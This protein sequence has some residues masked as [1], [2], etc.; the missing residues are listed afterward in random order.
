VAFTRHELGCRY[1]HVGAE[2]DQPALVQGMLKML[3][4]LQ[5]RKLASRC[6]WW[7]FPEETLRQSASRLLLQMMRYATWEDVQA[8]LQHYGARA[9]KDALV[10]APAGALDPRSWNFWHL[11]LGLAKAPDDVPPMPTRKVEDA[12]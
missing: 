10:S 3:S 8:A 9:F 11:Y 1:D 6:V 7:L 2:I 5:L 4:T 12:P